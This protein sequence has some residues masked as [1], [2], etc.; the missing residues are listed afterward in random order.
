MRFKVRTFAIYA[1]LIILLFCW[2]NPSPAFTAELSSGDCL[3][4]HE[5]TSGEIETA[6]DKAIENSIHDGM[7]C[8]DCHTGDS[9]LHPDEAYHDVNC[10]GC[11]VEEA[12]IYQWHGRLEAPDGEDVPSCANCH[13][14]HDV[15][16]SN[17]KN[18][19][20][21][22]IHLPKTCGTCHE[23]LDL[24]KKHEIF[25]QKPIQI[26]E[27]SVHGKASLGGIYLAAT[28]NDCHSAG[29]TAHRILSPGVAD[30]PINHFNIPQ[31]CGKCHRS[32]EK[33]YWEG[34]HGKLTARGETDSPVCTHC[35]GEHGII[36]PGDPRSPV[37][38][39]RIAEATCS[40]CHESAYLNEKYGAPLGRLKSFID[41]YHGLKSKA[42][43]L[44][45]ANC[46]SCHGAHRI[47]PQDDP[48]SSVHPANLQN[49]CGNCHP[50]ISP[51]MAL[52]CIHCPPGFAHNPT[53]I[54]FKNIYIVAIIVI[55]GSMVIHWLID[56]RK[57]IQ[58]VMRMPQIRRMNTNEV[59]QHT[60]IMVTF[61]VLAITGFS[62]RYSEAWWVKFLFGWEGGFALRGIIH[63]VSAGLFIFTSLW[64]LVYL[65]GKRGRK[66]LVDMWPRKKDF[67]QFFQMIKYNLDLSNEKP[68]FE[69]FNYIEKA[70]Y[71]ALV[72]GTV[73]MI[74]T[75]LFLWFDNL[76][77]QWFP[78]G[79]LEV[80]LVIHHYEA[81][82]AVLAVVIWH[83]YSTIFNPST[84]P[85]NPAWLTGKMPLA[86]YK[87]EHPEDKDY[88][89]EKRDP[90]S[91]RTDVQTEP[92]SQ[93]ESTSNNN[94]ED[95]DN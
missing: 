22:P 84:Y 30:S 85:M 24:I 15:L 39:A 5:S 23:D 78:K 36:S 3:D 21:H 34:I 86:Y 48:T 42:G 67:I 89:I 79:F 11:H 68:R 37:N 43:D 17:D 1:G 33:D 61:I 18:S 51:E 52:E 62:L 6:Y 44:T 53:A 58:N 71:W 57:E 76:A 69:R 12:A 95:I 92:K 74:V 8:L 28:C 14:R 20:V 87:H 19:R 31:T 73:I 75:G 40:P 35:H 72:W 7:D 10:G 70:E 80:M 90:R 2:I 55:I 38:P 41:S 45:V 32:V 54:V 93:V 4:C 81:W 29:G 83:L 49:T 94:R 82:L 65:N 47:L 77:V 66:F 50:S 16:P 59:W 9:G 60:F 64:H 26:Y 46:A 88:V 91:A 56:L 27:N 13:G 25:V 63:R